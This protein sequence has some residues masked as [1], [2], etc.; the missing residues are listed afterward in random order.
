MKKLIFL[1]AV[2]NA[3]N[4]AYG[5]TE[6]L[7]D[8][9]T[10]GTTQTGCS[11]II[12]DSGGNSG[13]YSNN[14]DYIVSFI[15]NNSSQLGLKLSALVNS[16]INN[17]DT[18]W[19]YDGDGTSTSQLFH[20]GVNNLTFFNSSNPIMQG[21]VFQTSALN[22]SKKITIRFKSSNN[23]V[24][25]GFGFSLSCS[26]P[27]QPI[28][29]RINTVLTIPQPDTNYISLCPWDSIHFV[30]YG[31]Y[32]M[33]DT[34]LVPYYHQSDATSIFTWSFGDGTTQTGTGLT[35]VN[36]HYAPG[37]GY[38]VKLSIKDTIGCENDN[39][40]G[41]RVMTSNNPIVSSK[42]I[43]DICTGIPF[44]ASAGTS[45]SS[46]VILNPVNFAQ[47]IPKDAINDTSLFIP[48]GTCNGLACLSSSI[49]YTG[50]EV[51][52]ILQSPNDILSICIKI[53]HSFVAD[54]HFQ[55][56]CP[57]GQSVILMN[58]TGA[59]QHGSAALGV[60]NENDNTANKCDPAFNPPGVGWTYC[61]SEQASYTYHGTLD[62]LSYGTSPIDSTDRINHSNYIV[63]YQSF[64]NL[65]GCPL[66]GT[67]TLK[68]CDLWPIDNG[69][70]FGWDIGFNPTLISDP[71]SYQVGI[72]NID[73]SGPFISN[74]S[75][76]SV[77]I[78]PTQ[79]GDYDNIV[80]ITDSFGCSFDTLITYHVNESPS[81]QFAYST[82]PNSQEV[83][84]T[85]QSTNAT[86]YLWNFGS[87]SDTSTEINP[88]YT[89]PTN[90][91]Y[92]VILSAYNSLCSASTSQLINLNNTGIDE[93]ETSLFQLFP[94]PTT[95]KISLKF[96]NQITE[97]TEINV[98]DITGKIV[99]KEV[100]SVLNSNQNKELDLSN[101]GSGV[102]HIKVK[103]KTQVFN[104]VVIVE[105]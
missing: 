32:P 42:L 64:S 57:N 84:F 8:A 27:C 105:R 53:E 73:W 24:A 85:N 92:T 34:L 48:D 90:G 13:N 2:L 81:A 65:I 59:A 72:N 19:I 103:N 21:D 78:T 96:D 50:F 30:A 99:Y 74:L 79:P 69:Y 98:I 83:V 6:V 3:F 11:F 35:A 10:D 52:Q 33:S 93:N 77:L 91:Q 60:V 76:S 86:S 89:Y 71:W 63:P 70:L 9:A 18:L 47:I 61:W 88:V 15:S 45:D 39:D 12:Y 87:N 23:P 97:N 46:T 49:T 101:L 16:A 58:T 7:V 1:I 41:L 26:K 38:R 94:N 44:I 62:T 37:I 67:W 95:G 31:Y 82:N 17:V 25:S 28:F 102:Y 43:A 80:T 5:Q 4:F 20:G 55:L 54:L 36:H 29:A 40:I 104:K 22:T 51:T 66:T 68:I 75:D 14:Q 100:I 56:V